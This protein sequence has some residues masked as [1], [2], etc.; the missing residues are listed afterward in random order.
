MY[1]SA[2]TFLV[3]ILETFL[4]FNLFSS[5]FIVD[6]FLKIKMIKNKFLLNL[7]VQTLNL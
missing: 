5:Y 4:H 3:L 1:D 7:C 6:A 2:L